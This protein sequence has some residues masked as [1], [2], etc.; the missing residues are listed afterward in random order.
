MGEEKKASG[1]Q[2]GFMPAVQLGQHPGLPH[3]PLGAGAGQLGLVGLQRVIQRK[4]ARREAEADLIRLGARLA[5]PLLDD[6]R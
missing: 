1:Q 4:P 5:P 6:D 2:A 3:R